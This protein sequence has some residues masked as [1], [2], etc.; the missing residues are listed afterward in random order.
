[1]LLYRY[2]LSS[3]KPWGRLEAWRE[4]GQVDGLGYRFELVTE[5]GPACGIPI[6]EG[7][8][9][10]KKGGR[11][12]IDSSHQVAVRDNSG[13]CPYPPI[14]GFVMAA[15]VEGEGKPSKPSVQVGAQHVKCMSD[16]ALFIALSAAID[17]SMDAC[18]LFSRKLR[19]EL[20]HEN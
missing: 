7:T 17:L 13:I 3:W 6:S 5:N 15:T 1:M 18:Q 8:M 19:K 4:T 14:K 12:C 9:S 11:F 10:V 16:V 20:C 2:S